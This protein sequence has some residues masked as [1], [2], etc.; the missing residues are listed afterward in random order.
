MQSSD[1]ILVSSAVDYHSYCHYRRNSKTK[2]HQHKFIEFSFLETCNNLIAKSE[3]IFGWKFKLKTRMQC[4]NTK[5]W[6]R[7]KN[8]NEYLFQ[9][10]K[11]NKTKIFKWNHKG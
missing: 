7:T 9:N 6:K 5:L 8:E 1:E 11:Q 2:T 4:E 3:S 10:W